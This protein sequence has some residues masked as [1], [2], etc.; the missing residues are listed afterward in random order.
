MRL[1][2]IQRAFSIK[3][4]DEENEKAVDRYRQALLTDLDAGLYYP[5]FAFC[6]PLFSEG[7]RIYSD[8]T[9]S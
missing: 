4:T 8:V 1:E 3:I 9:V 7:M 6:H 2:E 5:D